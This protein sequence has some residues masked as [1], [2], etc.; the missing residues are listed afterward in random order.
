M[1][2]LEKER[3]EEMVQAEKPNPNEIMTI[4][5]IASNGFISLI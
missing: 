3:F 2:K 4:E 1:C 5:I